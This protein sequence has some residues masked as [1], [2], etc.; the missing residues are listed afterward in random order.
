MNIENDRADIAKEPRLYISDLQRY[1][2]HCSAVVRDIRHV[3]ADWQMRQHG[4]N[5]RYAVDFSEIYSFVLPNETTE[6]APMA[7]GWGEDPELQFFVL[8]RFFAQREIVL[9]EPY[10]VELHGFMEA[11]LGNSYGTAARLLLTAMDELKQILT[12]KEVGRIEALAGKKNLTDDETKQIIAFFESQSP[13][14]VAFVRGADLPAIDLLRKL[15][16]ARPFVDLESLAPNLTIVVDP[17]SVENI[18][19]F[20]STNRFASKSAD[21]IDAL[22]LEQI[23]VAN[24]ALATQRPPTRL[25]LVTRSPVMMRTCER[26][27]SS[28]DEVFVRHP[29]IFSTA[30]T[31]EPGHDEQSVA[32]LSRRQQ[33]LEVFIQS[34]QESLARFSGSAVDSSDDA[35]EAASRQTIAVDRQLE[36]L[37][38]DWASV[39]GLAAAFVKAGEIKPE[40][41][42]PRGSL[43]VVAQRLL[44]FLRDDK[45]AV[46]HHAQRR[47]Q[48]VI[49]DVRRQRDRLGVSLQSAV[50]A[51]TEYLNILYPIRFQTR[52][53]DDHVSQL[54]CQWSATLDAA[55]KLVGAA[56][57][58]T[59]NEYEQLLA[60]S[61]SLGI[62][63][64]WDIAERYVAYA[65]DV[66]GVSNAML[67]EGQF[68]RAMCLRRNSR[69]NETA[70]ESVARIKR[71]L[72][73]IRMADEVRLTYEDRKADPRYLKERAALLIEWRQIAASPEDPSLFESRPLPTEIS[74]CLDLA[75]TLTT[76]SK[77]L[78]QISNAL[79][80]H[81]VY[82]SDAAN[83]ERHRKELEQYLS[84]YPSV[85]SFI[86]DTRA[87]ADFFL[88]GKGATI[89]QVNAWLQEFDLIYNAS[90]LTP[91]DKNAVQEHRVAVAR[92]RTELT[93][94]QQTPLPMI[95]GV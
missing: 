91:F 56:A 30:Y 92:F 75:L 43:Q 14:I 4:W 69:R 73:V 39:E 18:K 67:S 28:T 93:K 86:R 1:V 36:K 11:L 80:Y 61:L 49:D 38:K 88:S 87:W 63:G 66:G 32:E 50:R 16:R 22:A 84:A 35:K 59:N 62:L 53:L 40:A 31:P 34:A 94:S 46:A 74:D 9:L 95:H 68:W 47:I 83:A 82:E 89:E 79:C 2:R 42:R 19:Q 33:S 41:N 71:A 17:G 90:D 58:F 48:W 24:D 57:E 77:L 45:K 65:L 10:A 76:D 51:E 6:R 64:Q 81:Y 5:I 78:A 60:M 29:R 13:S 20:I 54:A 15:L 44:E 27:V 37:R 3:V 72:D 8:S 12:S 55:T 23:R 52:A 7:D 26:Y 21:Y 85:P 25:L 70:A